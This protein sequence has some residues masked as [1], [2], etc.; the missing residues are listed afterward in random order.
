[1]VTD[2]DF[3]VDI[4]Y[5]DIE[6]KYEVALEDSWDNVI[7]VDGVPVIDAGKLVKLGDRIAKAFKKKGAPI[8]PEHISTPFDKESGMSKGSAFVRSAILPPVYH[9]TYVKWAGLSL[10]SSELSTKPL[11]QST[12]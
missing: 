9:F 12:R 10:W 8:E 3:D 6:K 7:V 1:M 4:D 2:D 11:T 5:S